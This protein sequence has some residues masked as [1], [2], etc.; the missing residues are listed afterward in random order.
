MKIIQNNNP[1]RIEFD[2]DKDKVSLYT[3][4]QLALIN[5]CDEK[6]KQL[7]IKH[8]IGFTEAYN[9]AK[10]KN[11]T[12][13]ET[14]MAQ[15]L[16]IMETEKFRIRQFKINEA[17]MIYRIIST[18]KSYIPILL[19]DD[20]ELIINEINKFILNMVPE[21][22]I[23]DHLKEQLTYCD[24]LQNNSIICFDANNLES[25]RKN[26][27]NKINNIENAFKQNERFIH[28]LLLARKRLNEIISGEN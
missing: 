22:T 24:T 3:L 20:P 19:I 13:N 8:N 12:S 1:A 9:I 11:E 4:S 7:F 14:L 2:V 16:A 27:Q 15:L 6:V 26:I 21:I 28:P 5:N 17:K 18:N 23:L 25:K 10:I